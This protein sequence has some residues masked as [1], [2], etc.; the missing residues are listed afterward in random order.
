MDQKK[1]QIEHS[2][3]RGKKVPLASLAIF[4][5]ELVARRPPD[6]RDS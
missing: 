2:Y 6:Q 1:I 3:I 4:N 5:N